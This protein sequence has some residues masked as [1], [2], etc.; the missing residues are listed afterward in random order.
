VL[1]GLDGQPVLLQVVGCRAHIG[2]APA[3]ASQIG[4]LVWIA[5]RREAGRTLRPEPAPPPEKPGWPA[6]AGW[7]NM[8]PRGQ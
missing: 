3:G 4:L 7:R 5:L 8:S 6:S 1:T 2:P